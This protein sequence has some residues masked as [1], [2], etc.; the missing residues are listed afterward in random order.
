ME[1]QPS[2]LTIVKEYFP[3]SAGVLLTF[4]C[5]AMCEECCFE[6]GPKNPF[7]LSEENIKNII[8]QITE[9][10]SIKFIVWTGGEAFLNYK[11]LLFS[12]NYAYKKGL[13]SRIV[14]NGFWAKNKDIAKKK[15]QPLID[16]GLVELNISTGDNH[17]EYISIDNAL[18]A[19]V[20]AVELGI[21]AFISVEST[22][23]SL[24]K[25]EDIYRHELYKE[26]DKTDYNRNLFQVASTV[27]VSFHK[28]KK[29]TYDYEKPY[30]PELE[31]GCDG[32]FQM[33]NVDPKNVAL[34]CCG[35]G[36]EHINDLQLGKISTQKDSLV[37]LYNKQKE[38][39]M[40]QWL[41]VDGPVKILK[42]AKEWDSSIE[43]KT[44]VHYCQTC[45]YIFNTPKV[46]KAIK[47]NY[48]KIIDDVQQRFINKIKLNSYL[49]SLT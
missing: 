42:K 18:T 29:Y 40:K 33:I 26:L 4:K 17:Q 36:V 47:D 16:R 35:L 24:F 12:L 10:E 27:W 21:L 37:N 9:I 14:S 43:D 34:A 20:S 44:F 30:L 41:Y 11:L 45:A 13:C 25:E 6:C 28:D 22:G 5:N 38:D 3:D 2:D 15:L 31:N 23:N 8:D 19:A 48:Y 49:K 46:Q 7:T 32:L 39:F 1:K